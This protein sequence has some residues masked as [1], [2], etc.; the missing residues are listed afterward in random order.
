MTSGWDKGQGSGNGG[1]RAVH[2]TALT[3]PVVALPLDDVNTD[4]IVP[5]RFLT[6]TGRDGLGVHLFADW[7]FLPDGS[8]D[9]D[10]VLNRPEAQGARILLAGD[11]F[12]CGSSREHAAWALVGWGFRALIATSF[13]DIFH[14]NALQNGLLPVQVEPNALRRVLAIVQDDPG[15][16]VSIDL[17]SQILTLPT[18][19]TVTF[20]IDAFSKR[21]LL[22]GFDRL[23]YLLSIEGQISTYEA[24]HPHD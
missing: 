10:F 11:N 24:A 6:T 18:G 7:R 16:R 19:G 17:A 4:Q 22:A 9:L 5:A 12:G 21:C 20:P 8:P 3:S 23:D 13:A 14:A 2:F 1:R 15:A